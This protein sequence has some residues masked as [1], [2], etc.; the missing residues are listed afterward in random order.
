MSQNRA[1]LIEL[2]IGNI[3]NA[4][5]HNI[6]EKAIDM[7]EIADKY[8]KELKASFD[9]AKK[10]REKINPVN[11]ALPDKDIE[12]IREKLIRKIRAELLTR[13]KKGYENIN[14]NIV[15][16][17]VDKVLKEMNII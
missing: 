11:T 14:L 7:E 2:F 4:V 12:Y 3:S 15:E 8:R 16:E 6:L 13:I 5:I 9:I 17:E 1:R 10:Y